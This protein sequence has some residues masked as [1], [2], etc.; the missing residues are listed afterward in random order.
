MDIF[1]LIVGDD[2]GKGVVLNVVYI[3]IGKRI[4]LYIGNLI[5]WIID[6]DLIEVVYFLGVNDILEIKFFEN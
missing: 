6:E 4:V 5:W 1:L 2:V 3:Y